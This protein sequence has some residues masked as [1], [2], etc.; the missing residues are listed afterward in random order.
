[1]PSNA[2]KMEFHYVPAVGD[3]PGKGLHAVAF[4]PIEVGSFGVGNLD[5]G[6]PDSLATFK[7]LVASQR[8]PSESS[9]GPS[10]R[11]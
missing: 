1:M 5:I 10:R 9:T 2:L 6:P 7:T 3:K 8:L 4:G 11:L